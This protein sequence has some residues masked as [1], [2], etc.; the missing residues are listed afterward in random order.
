VAPQLGALVREGK[1]AESKAD[2]IHKLSIALK[3]ANEVNYW[4]K[5]L[6]DTKYIDNAM[7]TSINKDCLELVAILTAII[8][9][10]KSK[11]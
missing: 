1:Q 6:R 10:T 7:F 5:I 4:L 8:K 3:E 2:F 9:T 11:K